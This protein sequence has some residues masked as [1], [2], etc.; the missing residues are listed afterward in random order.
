MQRKSW[1]VMGEIFELEPRYKVVDYL[2]S[3]AYGTVCA[4]RDSTADHTVA[5]KKCKK[6][7][8]S[9]TLAK[10]TLREIRLLRMFSHENIVT[11]NSLLQPTDV[12]CFSDLYLV[13]EIMDTDLA[14][15]IRSPQ[16]LKEQHVQYFAHQ[17]LQALS[18]IHSKNIVHRDIKPRNILINADCSLK[19]ADFGLARMYK[20]E[21]P[22]R[23]TAITDYVTTRWYR[24]PEVIVGWT[25]YTSAVDMWAV[26]CIVA[27]LISRTPLFPGENTL[28]QIGLIIRIMGSPT[29]D[30][31]MRSQKSTFRYA[32]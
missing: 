7:F 9:R 11:L 8:S 29:E 30:F 2:G 10:R 18:Y 21:G 25:S 27:E 31:I 22:E 3:G 1:H 12:T 32:F 4:V 5:I 6:I 16:E 15:I 17:L 28:K 19:L 23:I 26:G 24:A 13:F 14:Q 20:N